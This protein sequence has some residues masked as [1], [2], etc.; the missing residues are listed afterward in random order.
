MR[1]YKLLLT[2]EE[3]QP[4]EILERANALALEL[5]GAEPRH[6]IEGLFA[7][8]ALLAAHRAMLP[9]GVARKRGVVE[10]A[11]VVGLAKL[12][13][14]TTLAEA[15]GTLTRV[16]TMAVLSDARGIDRLAQLDRGQTNLKNVN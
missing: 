15:A 3:S 6:A 1:G 14:C 9:N 7:D 12:E 4:P 2:P 8:S 11:L 10:A 16:E 5:P 13:D